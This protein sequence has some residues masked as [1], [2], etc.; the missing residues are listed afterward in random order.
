M[1]VSSSNPPPPQPPQSQIAIN[2]TYKVINSNPYTV[3]FNASGTITTPNGNTI[4]LNNPETSYIWDFGDGQTST[5]I[6]PVHV[7]RGPGTHHITCYASYQNSSQTG[8][9]I[10]IWVPNSLEGFQTPD[11]NWILFLFILLIM[12]FICYFFYNKALFV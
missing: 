7:F 3:Q 6:S 9:S 2:I 8:R 5:Q 4:N 1:G 10:S 12:I 11:N